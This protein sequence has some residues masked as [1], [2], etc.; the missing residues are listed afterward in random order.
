MLKAAE[1]ESSVVLEWTDREPMRAIISV[2]GVNIGTRQSVVQL[3]TL[4]D[5]H[6]SN[7]TINV[8]GGDHV[9]LVVCDNLSG[10]DVEAFCD[11]VV[12]V[13]SA[14]CS[15]VLIHASRLPTRQSASN[16]A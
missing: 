9:A 15:G 2:H 7:W 4:A 11:Q 6:F 13:L 8:L 1:L 10:D 14:S 5:K 3:V 12:A 16:G